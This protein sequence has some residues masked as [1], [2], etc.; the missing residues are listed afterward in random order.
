MNTLLVI[1]LAA[2]AALVTYRR[3]EARVPRRW[4]PMALRALAWG[5]LGLLLLN[6][7]CPS[8]PDAG[9]P[10]VLLDASLSMGA[11]SAR[12]QAAVDTARA[13]GT[14]RWFGD[15]RP[16]TDSLP[17]RGRSELGGALGAAAALGRPTLIITD[18]EL[19]RVGELPPDLLGRAGVLL[20]PR[21]T[22]PDLA[23]TAVEAPAR[24]T[25]GDS[26]VIR[27]E[28]RSFG[29][30]APESTVVAVRFGNRVLR[31]VAAELAPGEARQLPLR[32][33]TRG[34]PAGRRFLSVEL[35]GNQDTEPR[36]D[37]RLVAIDLLA[38]PGVV[39]LAAPGDWDARFLFRTLTEVAELPVKGYVEL[40]PGQWRDMEGLAPVTGAAVQAAAR[41][42]DLLVLRG[43]ADG[44]A[45]GSRARGLLRWLSAPPGP[46]EWYPTAVP[47][48]PIS[49]AFLGVATDSLPPL[50]GVRPHTPAAD[51]WT[52]LS[53]Q[54]G[55]R[56]A[57]R[58]VITGRQAGRRRE[59]EIN[60]DGFWRWAFRG[61]PS[62]DVYRAMVGSGVAW[63]LA[64]PDSGDAAVRLVRP[65]VEQ[66]MPLLFERLDD[67]LTIVPIALESTDGALSD[68]LR[69]GGDGR[70]ALWLP[71]G[72]YRYEVAG[73]GGS[74]TAAV[75]TWSREWLPQ[76][77]V[78]ADRAVP[79]LRS[80]GRKSARQLPWLYL[81]VLI[82][83][84]GEW[85]AR[86]RLG[87]R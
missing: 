34:M 58:P 26:V 17:D 23:V 80:A 85:L 12:W 73:P 39:V 14:V 9:R 66:G 60:A 3:F 20:L 68:T 57:A 46:E 35:I 43:A 65:V 50:T 18:G 36:D 40:T 55:R 72:S 25:L 81:L 75:D 48:S 5:G 13:R 21:A 54:A 67:S 56:G 70:A 11:D 74:G 62:G 86:R 29:S 59:I 83:L 16:W 31:R 24:A 82:S 79:S 19:Q 44:M 52:G 61:G 71:P 22:R 27:A 1:L 8:A 7:G 15:E 78:L 30:E 38:T 4:V 45:A 28:V 87:L 53:V 51:S 77:V 42:A 63:L 6:P 41:G 33:S 49:L 76:P 69:F 32:I 64:V 47:A 37:R 10:L 2:A 84:A